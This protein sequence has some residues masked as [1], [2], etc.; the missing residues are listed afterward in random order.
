M[1]T[2]VITIFVWHSAKDGKP[3]QYAADEFSRR[4]RCRK[5]FRWT[6]YRRKAG[7]RSWEEAEDIKRQLRAKTTLSSE[8]WCKV[9]RNRVGCNEETMRGFGRII[10]N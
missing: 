8:G 5:H 2:P 4:C 6:P 10:A 9:V 7:T 1:R 3:C